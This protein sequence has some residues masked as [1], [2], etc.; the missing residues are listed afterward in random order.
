MRYLRSYIIVLC[1]LLIA[2]NFIG[3]R[4]KKIQSSTVITESFQEALEFA[5]EHLPLEGKLMVNSD[6]F[7]YVKVDDDYIT[8]LFPRLGL[9]KEGFREV[10]YFRTKESPGAHITVFY[11]DEHIRPKEINQIFHF[12][13]NKIVIVKTAKNTSYAILEVDSPELENLRK[14]YGLSSK[15]FGHEFHI[16]IA[17]KIVRTSR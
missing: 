11:A 12:E 6:G 1:A 8:E 10:P 14:K 7:V 4:P 17:K 2:Y 3:V 16:S 13:L 5:R 15:I 9:K